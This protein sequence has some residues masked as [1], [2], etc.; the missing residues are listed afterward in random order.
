M[1]MPRR[2]RAQRTVILHDIDNTCQLPR[3][4]IVRAFNGCPSKRPIGNRTIDVLVLNYQAIRGAASV[5]PLDR[6]GLRGLYS[7]A[8]D[9]LA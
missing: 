7:G 4:S 2:T 6:M 9:S 1:S 3:T 8:I 5:I